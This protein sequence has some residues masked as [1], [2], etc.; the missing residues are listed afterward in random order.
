MPGDSQKL[1]SVDTVN[2]RNADS[3]ADRILTTL[4]LFIR[5]KKMSIHPIIN[6]DFEKTGGNSGNNTDDFYVKIRDQLD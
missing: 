6:D 2:I 1:K 4:P 5:P 3:H